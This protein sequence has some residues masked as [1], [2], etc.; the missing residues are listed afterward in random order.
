MKS[1]KSI[2]PFDQ[3]EIAEYKIMDN[4]AIDDALALSEKIFPHWSS[5]P[6]EY[7][8]EILKNVA[9]LL[10]ERKEP[11]DVEEE[12]EEED[13]EAE[14]EEDKAETTEDETGA[15]VEE[16]REA[17]EDKEEEEEEDNEVEAEAEEAAGGAG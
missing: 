8:A 2:F 10:L 6:F 3:T 11:P 1:F 15:E 9:W 17:E 14:D 16:L 5:K 4:A 7:R 12:E 13:E